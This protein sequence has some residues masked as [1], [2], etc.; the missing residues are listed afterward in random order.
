MQSTPD[1]L[2][3][4]LIKRMVEQMPDVSN[5]HHL[6]AW[7]LTDSEIHLEAHIELNKDLKLSQVKG[8]HQEIECLL[9]TDFNVNH[10]TLQFEI[11]SAHPTKLIH[12]ENG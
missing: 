6:H 11:E 5:I 8:T 3:L 10:V 12:K 9:Q 1:H 7:T 4:S 2:D